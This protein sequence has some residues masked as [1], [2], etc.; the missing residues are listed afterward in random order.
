LEEKI[1]QVRIDERSLQ[2][3]RVSAEKVRSELEES[4]IDM[5]ANPHLFQYTN[6]IIIK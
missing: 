4:I 1:K 6:A 2:S 5:Y 3:F